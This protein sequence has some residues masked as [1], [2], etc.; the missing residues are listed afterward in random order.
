MWEERVRA[1][2]EKVRES[3]SEK[4]KGREGGRSRG[5]RER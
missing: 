2:E 1:E 3:S 4:R 5:R